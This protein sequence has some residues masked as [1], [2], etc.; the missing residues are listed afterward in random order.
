MKTIRYY[1]ILVLLFLSLAVPR[2]AQAQDNQP[3]AGPTYIVQPGDTLYEIAQRFGVSLDD[4]LQVNEISD[5]SLLAVGQAL[6]IPGM[7]D[8]QGIL[9]TEIISFGDS[10]RGLLRRYQA[11]PDL[12]QRLNR[13]VSPSELYAGAA[14]IVPQQENGTTLNAAISLQAGQTPLEAAVLQNASIWT[15]SQ[16]NQVENPSRLIPG[17]ILY[18]DK[19]DATDSP[20]SALPPLFRDI[21]VNDL[22]L[23]QGATAEISV[24]T[25]SA[26]ELSGFL[27]DY[28]LHFF[29]LDE[30]QHEYV[31]LQGIHA[32]LP[33]G[34]YPV[35]IE[36]KT[37]GGETAAFEQMVLVKDGGYPHE[38]LVVPA[39]TI[40]PQ[41][42]EAEFD[43]LYNLVTQQISPE[44]YWEGQ[45]SNPSFYED[46]FTSRY[47][48]RRTYKGAGTDLVYEG[49]HSGLDFCGGEGL[50][51]TAPAAGRVVFSGLKTIRGNAT[52][53]D[54]GWGVYSGIWHQS[55]TYVQTGDWVEQ[56]QTIGLVGGT[57]RVTGAHLHWE[58]W[59][60]GV[61][62]NPMTWLQRTYP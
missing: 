61:Q 48:T 36:A 37:A 30:N 2:P 49:F 57:G 43:W 55:E 23:Y 20:V 59:V 1:L 41:T 47:G 13:L 9:T 60:N 26:A 58:I 5:P 39:E 52:V 45:F 53:I 46:C 15:L 24:Q 28:P 33:P 51:I 40:D 32:M 8:V 16:L 25:Q 62:V 38:I 18:L 22:P 11:Q 54:H 44:R 19:A 35:H 29:P 17:D 14:L 21:Q 10:W 34:L 7:E 27:G 56:G 31:A 6:V 42:N 4:L 50:P 12:L 3:P